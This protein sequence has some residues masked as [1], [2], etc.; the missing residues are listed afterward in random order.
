[1]AKTTQHS[2]GVVSQWCPGRVSTGHPTKPF[3]LVAAQSISHGVVS[4]K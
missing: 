1:M 4:F 2:Q 3:S